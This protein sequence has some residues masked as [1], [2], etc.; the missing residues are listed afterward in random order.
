MSCSTINSCVCLENCNILDIKGPPRPHL[1]FKGHTCGTLWVSCQ[2][3]LTNKTNNHV[4]LSFYGSNENIW[5]NNEDFWFLTDV[6][7]LLNTFKCE[8]VLAVFQSPRV[9]FSCCQFTFFQPLRISC[10]LCADYI[11]SFDRWVCTD[12]FNV[13]QVSCLGF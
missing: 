4:L 5:W 9:N 8:H 11:F 6:L 3:V 10:W 13:L 7:L 12:I 1:Q 2:L